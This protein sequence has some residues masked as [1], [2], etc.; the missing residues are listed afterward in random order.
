MLSALD[1]TLRKAA[2][3]ACV[4]MLGQAVSYLEIA[5]RYAPGPYPDPECPIEKWQFAH[6][7]LIVARDLLRK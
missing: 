2:H 7:H 6:E 3:E 4:F 5:M 1:R